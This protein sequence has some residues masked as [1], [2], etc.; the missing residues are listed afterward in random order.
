MSI[1]GTSGKSWEAVHIFLILRRLSSLFWE[2]LRNTKNTPSRRRPVHKFPTLVS[3]AKFQKCANHANC[4]W[5]CASR[6][7]DHSSASTTSA[8]Q[9]WIWSR[10]P[11][12]LRYLLVYRGFSSAG[13]ILRISIKFI[14][15]QSDSKFIV[16]WCQRD[17]PDFPSFPDSGIFPKTSQEI[18][19]LVHIF[20]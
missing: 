11:A 4:R 1:L 20:L 10:V 13:D 19:E 8:Y 9:C 12:N 14:E 17:V 18:C 5:C 15:S 3:K 6:S 16:I 2:F 7:S